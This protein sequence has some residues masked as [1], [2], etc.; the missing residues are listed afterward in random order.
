IAA[1]ITSALLTVGVIASLGAAAWRSKQLHEKFT[2]RGLILFSVSGLAGVAL[3][4]FRENMWAVGKLVS[5]FSI[6]IPI[7]IAIFLCQHKL[8]RLASTS[9]K[10]FSAFLIGAIFSWGTLNFILAG[11]RVANAVSESELSGYISHHGA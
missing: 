2:E 7:W 5:Y 4:L 3:L 11:S 9:S 1:S 10:V 8:N 6:L